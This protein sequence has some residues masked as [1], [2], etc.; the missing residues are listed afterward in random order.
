[1]LTMPAQTTAPTSTLE[2][3]HCSVIDHSTPLKN[4][5]ECYGL[6]MANTTQSE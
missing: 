3:S 2:R 5:P 6:V 4:G 1:V